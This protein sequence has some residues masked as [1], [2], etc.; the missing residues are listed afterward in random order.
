M[1]G[2]K[3]LVPL[4]WLPLLGLALAVSLGGD[5]QGQ[6]TT[7]DAPAKAAASKAT[8]ESR[9]VQVGERFPN[10]QLKDQD[11]ESFSLSKTLKNGPVVL[12]VY[13]SADW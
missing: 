3:S 4:A 8:A 1:F 2:R 7:K 6:V 11:G 10:V 12:V 9:S 13:R 5:C